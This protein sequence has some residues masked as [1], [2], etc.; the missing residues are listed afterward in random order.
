M[1]DARAE[2][3]HGVLVTVLLVLAGA[4]LGAIWAASVPDVGV[5][6]VG[7]YLLPSYTEDKA[8]AAGDLVLLLI[9]AIAGLVAGGLVAWYGRHTPVGGACGLLV[10]GLLA[11]VIAMAVGHVLVHGDYHAIQHHKVDGT[12]FQ[13]RPYI[14]GS[15]D[16]VLLPLIALILFGVVQL[17]LRRGT[18]QSWPFNSATA[19]PA[20]DPAP[21]SRP[22]R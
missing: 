8:S 2:V 1:A 7:S 22:P 17:S 21:V 11:G 19:A 12:T 16:F 3:R 14:R 20:S 5:F 4:P 10:G 18:R 6:R 9:L 13:V 15:G